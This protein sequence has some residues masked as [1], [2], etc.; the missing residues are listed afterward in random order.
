MPGWINPWGLTALLLATLALLQA[1]WPGV[2]DLTITLAILGVGVVLV[3]L[4]AAGRHAWTRKDRV[5][6]VGTG[7]LN[8][9]LLLLAI[10]LPGLLNVYWPLDVPAHQTQDRNALVR[11]PRDRLQAEG[12]P[13]TED[14]WVD[15]ATAAIRQYDVVVR[16]DS[17]R[18]G[19][20]SNKVDGPLPENGGKNY[21][22]I[23]LRLGNA[24]HTLPL[25]FE[26]FDN[27]RHQPLLR[28]AAGR[29]CPFV[30]QRPRKMPGPGVIVFERPNRQPR[31]ISPPR[32]ADY[33]LVFELPSS[34]VAN[35]KLELPASAWGRTG[36]CRFHI[37]EEFEGIS[38][39]TN[40]N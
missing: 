15:A 6:L 20:W 35:L 17:A 36:V 16:L 32:Y 10:F 31:T 9:F 14:D 22:R 12:Q 1:A 13:L 23:H 21:L 34:A 18:A 37:S 8:G 25:V 24:G 11:V 4:A 7:V 26:G 39:E 38:P 40:K 5:W 27:D 3:G 33:L 28:D 29:S 30:D 2:R 19:P